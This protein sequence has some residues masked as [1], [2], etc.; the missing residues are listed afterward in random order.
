MSEKREKG[1]SHPVADSNC[2]TVSWHGPRP[3]QAPTP[4]TFRALQNQKSGRIT[5]E[6]WG[7][8]GI[9]LISEGD[10]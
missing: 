5:P 6:I 1:C 7:T 9:N 10:F 3:L 2:R 4:D 8:G